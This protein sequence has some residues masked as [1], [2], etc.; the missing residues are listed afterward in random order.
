MVSEWFALQ[1]GGRQRVAHGASRGWVT[2]NYLFQ[3]GGR[4]SKR[5]DT[6]L[7]EVSPSGLSQLIA[8]EPTARA[9]GYPLTPS[10]LKNWI[11]GR[12]FGHLVLA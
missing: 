5:T 4:H 7:T 9:V 3:P 12:A 1:P 11:G 8:S 2:D 6:S 10:G